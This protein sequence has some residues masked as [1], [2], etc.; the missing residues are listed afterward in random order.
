MTTTKNVLVACEYS[1]TVRDAF[2][3]AGH[4]AISCD[5]LPSDSTGLVWNATK[6]WIGPGHYTGDVFD[7]LADPVRF[8]GGPIDLMVA[9]PPCTY[10]TNAG[11]RWL[12]EPGT[13]T[14]VPERWQGLRDGAAFFR[15]L[16]EADV[17]HIAVENPV[18]MGHAKRL[19]WD[20][21]GEP[22]EPTQ[23]F[24]PYEFGHMETKRT[25]LWLKDLPPLAPTN[26]VKAATMALPYGERAKVHHASPG[27]DRW[28][29]RS[30]FYRGVADA[31][32]TQWGAVL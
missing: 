5:L 19:L 3:R 24:Q 1:G 10:L 31:M 4:Y 23:T 7:I 9:H 14:P 22:M 16:W 15:A 13:R 17:P 29:L 18:M 8:F 20:H 21:D 30:T 27:P 28:K 26:D 12:Y 6:G 2:L 32:A 11:A 25:C